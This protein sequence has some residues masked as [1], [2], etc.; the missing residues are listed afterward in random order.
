MSVEIRHARPRDAAQLVELARAVGSE[1]DGWLIT[2]GAWRTVSEERRHLRSARHSPHHCILVAEDGRGIVG[3]LSIA[4]NP[5]PACAHVADIGLMVAQGAR[6]QGVGGALLA[7]AE[8]WAAAAGVT[9]IELH[10]F[11]HNDAALALYERAGYRREGYRQGQFRRAGGLVDAI[12]MAKI[13][14]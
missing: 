6:R 13:I 3:R 12:L 1:P 11:P 14:E 2:D 10:V 8:R 4:R 7:A 5:H 9:K